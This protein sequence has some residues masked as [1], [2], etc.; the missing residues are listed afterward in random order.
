MASHMFTFIGAMC[1]LSIDTLQ[2]T[3]VTLA[4]SISS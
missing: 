4:V 3:I 1:M 2:I